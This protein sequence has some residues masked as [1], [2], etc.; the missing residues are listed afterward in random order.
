MEKNHRRS[1]NEAF[2]ADMYEY[3]ESE[4]NITTMKKNS[5]KAFNTKCDATLPN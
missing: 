4:N 1:D 5:A 3:E 2:T